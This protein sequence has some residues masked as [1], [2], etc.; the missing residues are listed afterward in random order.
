[1]SDVIRILGLETSCDDTSVCLLEGVGDGPQGHTTFKKIHFFETFSQDDLLADWGGVVPE[2]AARNHLDKLVPLLVKSFEKTSLGPCDVDALAVTTHPGLLGPLLVGLGTAKTLALLHKLPIVS[3]N[4]LHA[5]LEAIHMGH[6]V[7]YP[8]LGLLVSGGHSLFFTVHSP[9]RF[10]LLGS[11]VDDA[12]GE[13]FDKGGRLLGLPYPCGQLIDEMAVGGDET[14]YDFPIGLKHSKDCQLSFSGVKTSLKNFV[15]KHSQWASNVGENKD[16][17]EVKNL[18]A[19]YQGA[20]VRALALKLRYARKKAGEHLP[21]VVGGGVACNS[22]LR[23]YLNDEL[24]GHALH[25]VP[26]AYCTDNGAMIAHLGLLLY[27]QRTPFPQCLSLDA[28]GQAIA[29]ERVR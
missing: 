21:V 22:R 24:K 11:T 8:Y 1:M 27:H 18:L 25:F 4:H 17:Q 2:I 13:A 5:H 19:S 7:S 20:I 14:A 26:P 23:S 16:C 10:E 6:E 15:I 12:A 29:K 9:N 3:I 28:K